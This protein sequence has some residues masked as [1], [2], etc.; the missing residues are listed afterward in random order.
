[1]KQYDILMVGP[2]P[3]DPS[4]MKGGVQA[5]VFGLSRALLSRDEV[6]SLRITALPKSGVRS[7]FRD[8]R[9]ADMDVVFLD[10]PLGFLASTVVHLPFALRAAVT[11]REPVVHVHGTGLFQFLLCLTCRCASV[12]LVWT[13]HGI[14]EKETRQRFRMRPSAAN[15]GRYVLYACLER[16]TLGLAPQ[17]I[18]DTPYVAEALGSPRKLSVIA[19]GIFLEEFENLPKRA[20]EPL[21]AS[22]GVLEPRKGHHMT[23]EAFALAK[24]K[25]PEA[26]L[27]IAGALTSPAYFE[28]LK[29]HVRALG[30][31]GCVD[32]LANLARSEVLSLLGRA[33]LFALHSQEESQGIA[34]CEA[35]AAGLPVVATR[36]G[37]IPHVVEDGKTGL[38]VDY[39]DTDAFAAA[40]ASLLE[41]SD[42]HARLSEAGRAAS[43]RFAWE[44]I[45]D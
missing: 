3:D 4:L 10:A 26:H 21:I 23:L 1:M 22:I 9:I 14:T 7:A 42:L 37:G 32:I 24:Q 39:G 31:E 18:V 20:A 45:A 43:L 40:I 38:L 6:R 13:L 2:F 12:P 16:A 30:L 34:L 28:S 17:V 25:I 35:L 41:D 36:V 27:A 5:S 19:Q 8:A 15:L 11:L 44:H 29:A 33:H